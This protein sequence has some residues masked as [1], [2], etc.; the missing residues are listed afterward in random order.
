MY[1]PSQTPQLTLSPAKVQLSVTLALVLELG[2]QSLYNGI[3]KT[4]IRVVVLQ[5]R[6]LSHLG[7]TS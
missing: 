3:S 6:F 4:A 1:H 2:N 7:Y 5:A